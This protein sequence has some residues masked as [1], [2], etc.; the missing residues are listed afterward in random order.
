MILVACSDDV[1]MF[2][3]KTVLQFRDVKKSSWSRKIATRLEACRHLS[4]FECQVQFL[5]KSNI[6]SGLA[7]WFLFISTMGNTYKRLYPFTVTSIAAGTRKVLM[8]V[9]GQN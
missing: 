1:D 2:I 6:F 9:G 8:R 5:R 3:P 7:S 4:P